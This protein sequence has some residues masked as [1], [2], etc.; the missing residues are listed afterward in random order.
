MGKLVKQDNKRA[1]GSA[2][3][4]MS[5][6]PAGVWVHKTGMK[7][8]G[9]NENRPRWMRLMIGGTLSAALLLA[10]SGCTRDPNVRKQRFVESG[11]KYLAKGKYREAE[12]E[13]QNAL[14]ID[15]GFLPAHTELAKVYLRL[16]AWG[17]AVK[18]L[19]AVLHLDPKNVQAHVELGNILLLGR[20][21]AG[22]EEH[23][24]AVLALAPDNVDGHILLA[25]ALS[26]REDSAGALEEMQKAL[27]L[28]PKRT[29]SYLNQAALQ[30]KAGHPAD[31]EQSYR[32]ALE[33]DPKSAAALLA[34]GNFYQ[35]QKRHA[36]A[37]AEY[38]EAMQLE[39]TNPQPVISLSRMLLA[40]GKRDQAEQTIKDAKPNL[41]K[42][43]IGYRLLAEFYSGLG[44]LGRAADEY[45]S[46]V[47]D[48][49]DDTRLKNDYVQVLIT[50]KRVD[51]ASKLN[52]AIL[53]A[54]PKDPGA[55]IAE[56]QIL[57]RQGKPGEAV[58]LLEPV[59]ASEPENATGQF[60]FG[61][62]L[63]AEGNLA[64]AEQAWRQAAKLRPD[65]PAAQEALA[66]LAIRKDDV[67]LLMNSA[68]A[69]IR[70]NPKLAN[71][72]TLRGLGKI[73]KG[74]RAGAEMDLNTAMSLAPDDP[75]PYTR[76]GALRDREKRFSEA[77]KYDEQA[78]AKNPDFI[79]ALRGLVRVDL[80]QNQGAK[81]IAR[82]QQQIVRSPSNSGFQ[83]LL[84]RLYAEQHQWPEAEEALVK[85]TT[86][87]S[88][89]LDAF[90]LLAQVQAQRGAL[91]RAVQNYQQSIQQHPTDVRPYVLLGMLEESRRD[92]A[93]AR[94]LYEK[95]LQVQ[96]NNPL[97]AN[98]LAYLLLETGGDT[99]SALTLAQTARQALPQNPNVADTLAWVYYQKGVYGSAADLLKEA[100]HAKPDD[101]TFHY[102]LGMTYDKLNDKAHAREELERALK[103]NPNF[104][105]AAEIKQVLSTLGG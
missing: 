83:V 39:P 62:A 45:A 31:A 58:K 16:G 19:R 100:V 85:A 76:M 73:A 88:N 41:S 29:T 26:A 81:A 3:H 77:E 67:E 75:T 24:R 71:G 91:D 69:L 46:L 90:L 74:D 101:A 10:S 5:E 56:G 103:L 17:A 22:G 79:E 54:A 96:P 4:R 80:E 27:D 13:Y 43:P 82:V 84:A 99:N 20:D 11:D 48:H 70:I 104:E 95:A 68:E 18:E 72:Y 98:N 61:V 105:H 59:V 52:D 65:L 47:Q 7:T 55:L 35:Q 38:R 23:A 2:A 8:K 92:L 1:Q 86:M 6:T 37:E 32:K 51:E 40:E 57:V 94:R 15:A 93:Q 28:D 21:V 25:N 78:L 60:Q 44:D 30:A 49:P 53:K 33:L 63:A 64:R 12:I 87:D 66:E 14:Q 97:A 9:T 36:E 34:F 89:N 42:N 102:H 50:A